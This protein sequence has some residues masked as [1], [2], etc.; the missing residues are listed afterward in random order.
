MRFSI[1]W[2]WKQC[3]YLCE[4]GSFETFSL[5]PV[6][7]DTMKS[8]LS[9]TLC[10]GTCA[11]LHVLYECYS[12]TYEARGKVKIS[13][14]QGNKWLQHAA[15]EKRGADCGK[16]SV[17]PSPDYFYKSDNSSADTDNDMPAVPQ[18]CL[19]WSCNIRVSVENPKTLI[20]SEHLKMTQTIV[21]IISVLCWF[22]AIFLS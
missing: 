2:P 7:F 17:D 8:N 10:N 9:G 16:F 21:F 6:K 19:Q 18:R 3:C 20:L 11:D 15:A 12:V 1:M 13:A 4:R 22:I 14:W 5:F